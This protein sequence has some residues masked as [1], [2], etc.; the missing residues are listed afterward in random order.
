MLGAPVMSAEHVRLRYDAPA[1]SDPVVAV[2]DLRGALVRMISLGSSAGELVWDLRDGNGNR[3]P[4]GT[5]LL[6]LS[7]NGERATQVVRVVR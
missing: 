2:H 1:G 6:T 3:V 7:A 5:Y 4:F